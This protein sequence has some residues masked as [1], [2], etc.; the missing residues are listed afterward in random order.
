MSAKADKS[1]TNS[2]KVLTLEQIIGSD[3]IQAGYLPRTEEAKKAK[4]DASSNTGELS[5]TNIRS[6]STIEYPKNATVVMSDFCEDFIVRPG[7]V[8]FRGRV[9]P[10]VATYVN[11]ED[12]NDALRNGENIQQFIYSSAIIRIRLSN[13]SN[14]LCPILPEYLAAYI[15][16]PVAQRHF[17]KH[18]QGS[19]IS[20][21]G[22]RDLLTLPVYMPPLEDQERIA[23]LVRVHSEYKKSSQALVD[24]YNSIIKFYFLSLPKN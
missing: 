20:G 23:E 9:A 7:D 11:K 22:K 24:S 12:L 18:T 14:V 19:M 4:G 6:D 1:S 15:N 13:A 5:F 16:S 3:S 10:P 2:S 21:V 17:T 8:L